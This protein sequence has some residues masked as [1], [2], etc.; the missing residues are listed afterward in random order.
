MSTD[1]EGRYDPKTLEGLADIVENLSRHLL[2]IND[3]D[4]RRLDNRLDE[5]ERDV[6]DMLTRTL[7]CNTDRLTQLQRQVE[8]EIERL[9][10]K[11]NEHERAFRL[12]EVTHR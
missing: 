1:A 7:P 2:S 11:L 4:I 6:R 8:S 12:L 5:I 9:E 3:N 10:I